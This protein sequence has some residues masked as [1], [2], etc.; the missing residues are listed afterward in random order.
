MDIYTWK[1]QNNVF[2][3]LPYHH[4]NT[5]IHGINSIHNHNVKSPLPHRC[6]LHWKLSYSITTVKIYGEHY[7][8]VFSMCVCVT[9]SVYVLHKL[10]NLY[11]SNILQNKLAYVVR[12]LLHNTCAESLGSFDFQNT[13]PWKQNK[14]YLFIYIYIHAYVVLIVHGIV[15]AYSVYTLHLN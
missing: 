11:T 12:L 10:W 13:R 4:I 6:Y 3:C 15:Y 9:V 14:H 7:V 2:T 8:S 5:C 1:L